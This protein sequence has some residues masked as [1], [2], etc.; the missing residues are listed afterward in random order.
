MSSGI[1]S[2]MNPLG[3]DGQDREIEPH[4]Y[5]LDPY[6]PVRIGGAHALGQ[7]DRPIIQQIRNGVDT[8]ICQRCH[9]SIFLPPPRK[10][11]GR[12]EESLGRCFYWW[13]Q[14]VTPRL[15]GR[16]QER[17][18]DWTDAVYTTEVTQ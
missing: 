6:G 5:N 4:E 9:A 3:L 12:W 13:G 14:H 18:D 17:A 8:C 2:D 7:V 10:L 1:I 11:M 15:C 16:C